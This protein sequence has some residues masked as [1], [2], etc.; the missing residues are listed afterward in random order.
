MKYL[1]TAKNGKLADCF[2]EVAG[3]WL[4]HEDGTGD[5]PRTWETVSTKIGSLHV[6]TRS[7]VVN[8][9]W[10]TF[11]GEMNSQCY[12]MCPLIT[13]LVLIIIVSQIQLIEAHK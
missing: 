7:L 9:Y 11:V 1:S 8:L 13:S 5:S 4:S 12:Y 6:S 2:I 3:R 10:T